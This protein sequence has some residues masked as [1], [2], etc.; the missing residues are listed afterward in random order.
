MDDS[1]SPLA[2]PIPQPLPAAVGGPSPRFADRTR[3]LLEVMACSGFPT[4]IGLQLGFAFL[5]FLPMDGDG[6]LRFW[7]VVN[8]QFFDTALLIGLVVL[9]LRARGDNMRDVFLGGRPIG[10]EAAAGVPLIFGAFVVAIAVL[11]TI[12]RAAPWLHDVEENPLQDLLRQPSQAALFAVVAVVGG[13]VRE[14]IQRAFLLN[15]FERWL[16]GG[17][18][19]VVA[20]SLAFGLGHQMQGTDAAIATGI[21]GAF[22]GLVY[23]RRRSIVA[24]IVSHSGFNLI[25]LGQFLLR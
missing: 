21:L 25:Q 4:Q 18:V 3:A 22:W 16:G 1:R 23:L 10:A 8:L 11:L 14:E 15:R 9:F 6:R 20:A 5:G 19:G 13:G 17:L 7:Y 12:Q 24:P 2:A